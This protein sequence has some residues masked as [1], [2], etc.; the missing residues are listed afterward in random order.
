MKLLLMLMLC[1][2]AVSGCAAA[3]SPD[4][5]A[6]LLPEEGMSL[7]AINVGKAD[8]LLL[9]YEDCTYLID[10]GTAESWGNVSAALHV[11]G[12]DHLTGVIVTHTDGDHAG[13]AW[14]LATSSIQVDTWYTSRYYADIKNESKHPVVQAAA[15]RNE[16]VQWLSQGDVLPFGSGRLTVLGPISKSEKENCNSVVLL[17]E[18]EGGSMLLTGDMEFPEETELMDAGL[19][20]RCTVLKVGNHGESDATSDLF[21]YTVRPQ[22]AVISTN[23]ME[24]PDTPAN[25]VMKAL[26]AVNASVLQTQHSEAGVLV[27]IHDSEVTSDLLDYTGLPD[28]Q[29]TVALADKDVDEQ[30]IKL[31]NTGS[32]D[33]DISG[34]YLRSE[35]GNEIFV[36]P[37]GSVLKAGEEITVSNLSSSKDGDYVWPDK[38]VWHRSKDDAAFLY[39]VYGRKIDQLN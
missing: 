21:A 6:V 19:I 12:I 20:S 30:I 14:A 23:T 22:V 17:A 25:R 7:L 38:K 28:I 8:A 1:L 35:R 32:H 26:R 10:T 9:R 18:A 34:W 39:D 3:E 36:F 27:T 37:A 2:L 5:T 16:S 29:S 4:H 24:E 31:R 15:L 13:G 11:G 33:V